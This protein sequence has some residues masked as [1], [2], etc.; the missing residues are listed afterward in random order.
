MLS[1]QMFN[2]I[3]DVMQVITLQGPIEQFKRIKKYIEE[4]AKQTDNIKS[5][6]IKPICCGYIASGNSESFCLHINPICSKRG[7]G[8]CTYYRTV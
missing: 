8:G 2:D 5:D 7:S 3:R 6:K 4:S 1:E